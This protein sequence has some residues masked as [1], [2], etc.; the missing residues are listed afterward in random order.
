MSSP[1]DPKPVSHPTAAT[2]PA[3]AYTMAPPPGRVRRFLPWLGWVA[4]LFCLPLMLSMMLTVGDYFGVREGVQEKFHSLSPAGTDK[5]AII[6]IAG[7]IVDG[8]D[9]FVK[10]QIDRVRDDKRVKGVV[11]RINSPGGT[12]SAADYLFHHLV[13]LREQRKI[14]LVVS[15][16]GI[17]ASGGYYVAMAVGDQAKSIY[18]EPTTTTGSIGVIV[19]HYNVSGLMRVLQIDDDSIVSN[20][21]K[22][23]LSMTQPANAEHRAIIQKY[24][25]EAAKRFKQIV[26]KGRPGFRENPNN[27]DQIATGEIFAA[28]EARE[29]GLIDEIGFLEDAIDRVIE[30]AG[31]DR[32][33]TRVVRYKGRATLMQALGLAEQ[34]PSDPQIHLDRLL[35]PQ[36]WYLWTGLPGISNLPLIPAR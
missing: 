21:R 28:P 18:A 26:T 34:T 27:L 8:E 29:N 14:P 6:E 11:V 30:L 9:G 22:Q 19:P 13:K 1:N 3:V 12:I 4:F 15:M 36:A 33:K 32:K 10:K 5:V 31:L 20:E 17:A 25:D 16:G 24:V 7:A 35:T 23:M 2:S